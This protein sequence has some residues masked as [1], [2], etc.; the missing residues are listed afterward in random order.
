MIDTAVPRYFTQT[1]TL[2]IYYNIIIVLLKKTTGLR[3]I[4]SAM[5]IL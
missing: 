3:E 2:Y 1:D 4:S 5:R